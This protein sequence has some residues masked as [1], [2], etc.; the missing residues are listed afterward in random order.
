MASLRIDNENG[1]L[2]FQGSDGIGDGLV[3]LNVD[4][5]DIEAAFAL[6]VADTR[7]LVAYLIEQLDR[8]DED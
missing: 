4:S 6:T 5:G 7:E 3:A 8:H 2:S 1:S